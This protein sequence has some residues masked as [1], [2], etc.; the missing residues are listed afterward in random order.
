MSMAS[1]VIGIVAVIGVGVG[2]FPCLGWMNWLNLPLGFVGLVLG[3]FA[4]GAA[5]DESERGRA[6]GGVVLNGIALVLGFARLVLGGGV[7]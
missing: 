5:T 1:M 6:I 4:I 7:F 3:A 2:M